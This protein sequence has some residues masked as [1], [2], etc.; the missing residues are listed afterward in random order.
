MRLSALSIS[1]INKDSSLKVVPLRSDPFY[2]LFAFYWE[3]P[4]YSN[5]LLVEIVN[6]GEH[7]HFR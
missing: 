1:L 2:F 6:Y 5:G 4:A 3:I 7:L